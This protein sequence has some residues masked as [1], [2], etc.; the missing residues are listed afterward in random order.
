MVIPPPPC[1]SMYVVA[2]E[3]GLLWLP[4]RVRLCCAPR[5]HLAL[6]IWGAALVGCNE[7]L[8]IR[9]NIIRVR[10]KALLYPRST[11]RPGSVLSPFAKEPIY[12]LRGSCLAKSDSIASRRNH[13]RRRVAQEEI[14]LMDAVAL[15]RTVCATLCG[16]RGAFRVQ[17]SGFWVLCSG[18]RVQGLGCVCWRC[19]V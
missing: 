12:K 10:V 13:A 16:S 17:G 6:F 19:A 5:D 14:H 4:S 2:V 11:C 3:S 18:F 1:D 15:R 9:I 8:F 7:L